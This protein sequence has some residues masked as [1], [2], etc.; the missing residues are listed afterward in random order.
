[1][2]LK[3]STYRLGTKRKKGE[4]LRIGVTRYLPRGVKKADYKR[5]DYLDLWLPEVAPSRELISA[6]KEREAGAATFRWFK[7]EYLNEL[8]RS[9]AAGA[10]IKL[11][12]WMAKKTPISVGCFCEDEDSCHRS[13][14]YKE[15]ERAAEHS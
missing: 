1:M 15:I 8:K 3:L 12:A 4:G 7:R 5:L 13:L 2:G 11:L 6:Y 10:S 14:L 9:E